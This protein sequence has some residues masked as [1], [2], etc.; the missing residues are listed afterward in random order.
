MQPGV[1]VDVRRGYCFLNTEFKQR[2]HLLNRDDVM[3][4]L[5][6][7]EKSRPYV[8]QGSTLAVGAVVATVIATPAIL[9]GALAK[10]GNIHMSDDAST[11]LLVGGVALGVVSW[12][13]CIASDGRYVTAVERY[14]EHFTEPRDQDDDRTDEN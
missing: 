6:K 11:G 8:A 14:N 3:L 5:A 12:A 13:L 4:R 10:E 1:P 2:G 7:N 9:V